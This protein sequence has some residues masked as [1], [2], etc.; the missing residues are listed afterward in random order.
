M[1]GGSFLRR[2]RVRRGGVPRNAGAAGSIPCGALR[3]GA[4]SSGLLEHFA[5]RASGKSAPGFALEPTVD[6]KVDGVPVE[7]VRSAC[8]RKS[9]MRRRFGGL[10]PLNLAQS[11]N[12]TI[13]VALDCLVESEEPGDGLP[14]NPQSIIS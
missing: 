3:I 10:A 9:T 11:A 13:P 6:F 5:K 7:R 8:D 14:A 4:P 12:G 1:S 2:S